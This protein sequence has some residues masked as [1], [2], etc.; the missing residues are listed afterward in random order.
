MPNLA[1]YYMIRD[2]FDQI[3]GGAEMAGKKV[4]IVGGKRTAFGKFGGSLSSISPRELSTI[5]SQSLL[6]EISLDPAKIDQVILG[7]VVPSTS[8][9]LYGARH[10]ALSLG[11]PEST[12]A[13]M[14]NRLCGSGMQSIVDA[15][16]LILLGRGGLILSAGTENMSMVPHLTYGGRFG[17]KY[18]AL[19]SVDLLLDALTD[20]Y[21]GCAMGITAE[22]LAEKYEISR[23]TCEEYS[24]Q[25]HLK[26]ARAYAEKLMDSQIS[27]VPLKQQELIKDEH[28]RADIKIED[29]QKLRS[30]FKKDGTVTPATASGIVDGA[31][32]VLVASENEVAANQLKP[33]AEIIDYAV[34]GV[35]PKVMGIGPVPASQMLLKKNNLKV[36]DIDLWEIN[37]AF[38]S[39]VIA[40]Q[41]E[42]GIP[43]E[44]LNIW[45]G[46][47]ACGHPLG[48]TGTRITLNLAMQ[49]RHT[50]GKLGIATACIGG[51]QGIAL[52]LKSVG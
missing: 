22:N 21:S 16:N 3:Q 17:T 10:L 12:P 1:F 36:A 41:R 15:L 51:G 37:E 40:C 23:A 50:G 6:N 31:S 5:C 19:K 45:G 52:L 27:P 7:N 14:V 2:K 43:D 47:I 39:Q 44:K 34:I 26:L 38:A 24:V 46:S 30:N 28:F 32:S 33:L 18:G 4:Y 13:Y 35:D 48:A 9:T 11:C 20:Q 49:L 42:L 8:D 25:S 29:M